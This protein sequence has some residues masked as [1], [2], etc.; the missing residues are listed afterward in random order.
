M[1][2]YKDGGD[3]LKKFAA[4]IL[5]LIFILF[6]FSAC[7]SHPKNAD[8]DFT[9]NLNNAPRSLDPLLCN[10]DD[11]LTVVRALFD[12]LTREVNGELKAAAAS[13]WS[14]NSDYTQFTFTIR[15]NMYWRGLTSKSDKKTPVTA[16]DFVFAFQ[17]AVDPATKSP[18]LSKFLYFKNAKQISEGSLSPENLGVKALND[19]T[20]LI[21]LETSYENLPELL[22]FPAFAPCN[23][24]YFES[25]VGKYALEAYYMLTNG[26]FVFSEYYSWEK[27]SYIKLSRNKEYKNDIKVLPKSLTFLV[28][29]FE[30]KTDD[31]EKLI[32]DGDLQITTA[33]NISQVDDEKINIIKQPNTVWGLYFN[34]SDDLMKDPEIRSAFVHTIDRNAL[35]SKLPS[36]TTAADDI[37]PSS[38][39]FMGKNYRNSVGESFLP[40]YDLSFVNNMESILSSLSYERMPSVSVLCLDN[41]ETKTLVNELIISW[42]NNLGNYFNI[43]PL[44]EEELLS[45]VKNGNY[46][47]ALCPI[48][49]SGDDA[50]SLLS[51]F[52]SKSSKNY[53]HLESSLFDSLIDNCLFG[54]NPLSFCKQ[55]EEYLAK[56]FIFYPVFEE[57]SYYMSKKTVEGVSFFPYH[58]GLDFIQATYED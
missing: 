56:N 40:N 50:Y 9:Y 10:N 3:I 32:I 46:K 38:M 27:N 43:T 36:N 11:S 53:A 12:C 42:N 28:E 58:T 41:E 37:I 1:V 24:E 26:P 45:R 39:S 25:T 57:Y 44:S 54:E 7:S 34:T 5:C 2:L 47:I 6:S 33:N 22:S 4:I 30:L 20:L 55:S 16:H 23:K 48:S 18:H 35:L 19:Y 14:S 15:E 49:F 8:K 31:P 29:G 21:E 17:R 51:S 52:S 13:T